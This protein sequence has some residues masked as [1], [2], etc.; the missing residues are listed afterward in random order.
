[1]SP[2]A[3]PAAKLGLRERKKL[4]TREAIQREAMRLFQKHG[5]EET[6]IE[7][8]AAGADISPST[9]FNYFPSKEDVVLYDAYDPMLASLM[10]NRPADEPLSA[11]LRHV[12]Q[13]M[14]TI[15]TRDH[16]VILAR[17][18]LGME[19]PALRARM[20][21]EVQRAQVL[22]C[23]LIAERTGR[24]PDDFELR[25]V[26]MV[27]VVAA[28]EAMFEWIKQGGRGSFVELVNQALDVVDAGARLD[29]IAAPPLS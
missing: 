9:F 11:G 2:A 16:D 25:V 29:A 6:T 8:I 28:L 17:A 22:L 26:V 5:Y 14:E 27:V 1:M 24:D 7:Q 23:G 4:R 3:A 10:L 21:E 12:L 20:W 15:F 13:L 18:K 19:V